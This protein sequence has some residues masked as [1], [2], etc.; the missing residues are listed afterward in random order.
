MEIGDKEDRRFG[1]IAV[2][3]GFI[4]EQ[5]L[6]EAVNIQMQ[7]DLEGKEHRLIG[8]IMLDKGFMNVGQIKEV[9]TTL[10]VPLKEDEW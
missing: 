1:I 3:K 8:A 5:Q 4:T 2:E 6:G 7:D 9:L 10:G